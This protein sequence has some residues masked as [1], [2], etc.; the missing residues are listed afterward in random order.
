M[1]LNFH[2]YQ[3]TGN[4]FVMIDNRDS[5]FDKNNLDLV[6]HLCNR[7]FG[8]GADGLILIENHDKVDFDMIYFNADGTKS[9]CGNGS[10]CAV[11]FAKQLN[12]IESKTI[13]NAIDGIHEATIYEGVVEL[14][15]GNV[16]QVEKGEDYFFINTGSPHYI[17]FKEDIQSLDIVPEAHRI[18]YN[19]RF[20]EQGTNVNF[21]QKRSDTLEIRTYERGVE[22]ETL[23]CGT[24]ATA[25]AL[26]GAIMYDMKSPVSIKVQGGELK[27]KFNQLPQQ[28]FD[29]IWLIGKGENV[30]S[31][32]IEI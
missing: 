19:S 20:R 4:D 28:S 8:I 17:E 6:S 7:K 22:D 32:E 27:I 23:S 3:G 31:G 30:Y 15:M 5:F 11:A 25:V 14:K 26:S 24:G 13:F 29:N 21:V 18:R 2:K 16:E 1:T 10:R 12:I 9:F